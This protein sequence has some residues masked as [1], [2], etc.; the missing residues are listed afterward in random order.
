VTVNVPEDL[1]DPTMAWE[2]GRDPVIAKAGVQTFDGKKALQY[3]RSRQ[4]SND[5]AR[6]QRQRAVLL[7]LK[8]QVN[9]LGTLAN[10]AKLSSLAGA[11][12]NNVQTD[13]GLADAARFAQIIKKVDN[14][15]VNSIGRADAPNSFITTANVGGQ[16]VVQPLAGQFDYSA[17]QT[18][19][20]AQLKDPYL[21]QE[22]AKIQ[23][24]NGTTVAGLASKQADILK[25]YGYTITGTGNA[26]TQGYAQTIIVDL[27]GDT[28][29][30]TK[31]YLEQRYGVTVVTA[32]PDAAILPNGA[33][34]VIIV[35]N[36]STTINQG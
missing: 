17:I 13:L 8:E 36:D 26:P 14:S 3:S 6:S 5:F 7:A 16:S 31:R 2:N 30:F 32:S 20:R 1:V 12:G 23:V 21:Q 25:S 4:T 33:D 9:T 18:F 19:V 11:F 27:S 29:K 15:K 24:Y 35:G 10:P 22:Q 28:K 34:F